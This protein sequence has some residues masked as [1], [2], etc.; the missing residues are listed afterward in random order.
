[1]HLAFLERSVS[2]VFNMGTGRTQSF[3]EVAEH[4]GVPI[5]EIPMPE[6]LRHCYQTYTCAD[7]TKTRS[8]LA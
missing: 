5:E 2:G 8:A 1:M 4:F 7:M 3:Y 6:H